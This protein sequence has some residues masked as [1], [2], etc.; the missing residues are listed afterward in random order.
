[1]DRYALDHGGT[2]KGLH[3]SAAKNHHNTYYYHL[4]HNMFRLDM[5]SRTAKTAAA[6]F[7]KF[8]QLVRI[9]AISVPAPGFTRSHTQRLPLAAATWNGQVQ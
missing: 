7:S 5:P 4:I 2:S 9:R 8:V 3:T 6:S 1:M